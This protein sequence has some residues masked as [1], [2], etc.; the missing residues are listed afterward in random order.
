M[1]EYAV[2]ISASRIDTIARLNDAFTHIITAFPRA[3]VEVN[4]HAE[5]LLMDGKSALNQGSYRRH[6]T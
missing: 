3:Y 1:A 4:G 6:A 5:I 2:A